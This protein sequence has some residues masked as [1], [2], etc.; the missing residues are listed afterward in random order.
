[1]IE[2]VIICSLNLIA[3]LAG[4]A[5]GKGKSINPVTAYQEHKEEKQERKEATLK[6]KQIKTML[7]NIDNYNGSALVQEKIPR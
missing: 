7:S 2:I 4:V 1:M 3:L 6:E 5:I